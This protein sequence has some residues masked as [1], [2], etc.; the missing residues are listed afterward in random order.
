MKPLRTALKM[1]R[2]C[3]RKP[4]KNGRWAYFFE[5]PSWA[6]KQGCPLEAEALLQQFRHRYLRPIRPRIRNGNPPQNQKA[7]SKNW[8]HKLASNANIE[9]PF[10]VCGRRSCATLPGL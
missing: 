8:Q 7:L 6:R 5:L 10:T 2:Y 1:P 9:A 4:L 3:C